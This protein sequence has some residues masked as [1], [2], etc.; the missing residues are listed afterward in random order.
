MTT[1]RKATIEA[2]GTHAITM[3]RDFDHPVERVFRAMNEPEL[4]AQWM[5]PKRLTN[6]DVTN[7][8]HHG[9]TWTFTQ[10]DADGNEYRFRGV[11]HGEQTP[12]RSQRTFEWLGMPGHVS[13]E[14]QRLEDLGDGRTRLHNVSVFTSP[15]DRDGMLG[16]G[17]ATGVNEGY[18]RLDALLEAQ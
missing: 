17:M 4:I 9:G 12:E 11:F 5:G 18:E 2:E 8:A 3:V 14:T 6:S 7:E 10:R 15:K 16:S 13:F 1:T